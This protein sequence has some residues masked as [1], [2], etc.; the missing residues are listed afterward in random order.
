MFIIKQRWIGFVEASKRM[1][2]VNKYRSMTS[3]QL[4]NKQKHEAVEVN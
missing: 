4:F 2:S 3:D 1:V